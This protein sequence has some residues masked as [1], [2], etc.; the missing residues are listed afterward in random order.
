VCKKANIDIR[1]FHLTAQCPVGNQLFRAHDA[2]AVTWLALFRQAGFL[3]RVEDPTCFREEQDTNKRADVVVENWQ[4]CARP[5]S[6]C[7]CGSPVD[8]VHD[9][10]CG[11]RSKPECAAKR[12]ELEKL[13]KCQGVWCMPTVFVALVIES[14]GRWSIR[15]PARCSM[16]AH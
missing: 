4:G 16:C 15:R 1:G 12:Q 2:T 10:A 14:F 7:A 3:C 13:W 8:L 11:Q 6:M 5:S 9:E